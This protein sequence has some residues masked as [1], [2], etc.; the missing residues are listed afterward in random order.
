MIRQLQYQIT[1]YFPHIYHYMTHQDTTLNGMYVV[2]I[3]RICTAD[4]P[5]VGL[6]SKTVKKLPIWDDHQ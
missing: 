5:L 2:Y 6:L 4:R 3:S 1:E